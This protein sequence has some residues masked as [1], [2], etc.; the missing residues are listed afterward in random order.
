MRKLIICSC[1]ESGLDLEATALVAPLVVLLAPATA[2]TAIT[3]AIWI[4]I[5]PSS[6]ILYLAISAGPSVQAVA[7][8]VLAPHFTLPA[9]LFQ[10]VSA[11]RHPIAQQW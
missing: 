11:R 3:S 7:V 6:L 9:C 4:G 10:T 8:L 1:A 5:H 2:S